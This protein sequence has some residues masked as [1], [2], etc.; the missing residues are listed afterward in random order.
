MRTSWHDIW[1]CG[2]GP[3]A[4]LSPQVRILS[5]AVLFAAVMVAPSASAPNLRRAA[6]SWPGPKSSTMRRS[7]SQA[8]G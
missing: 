5:G 3:V 6:A 2:R 8:G 1:G 4:G 7:R